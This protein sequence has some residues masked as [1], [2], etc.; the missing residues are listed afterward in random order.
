MEAE[1]RAVALEAEIRGHK[2]E[3]RRRRAQMAQAAAALAELRKALARRG[4]GLRLVDTKGE[5]GE[6]PWPTQDETST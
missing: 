3:I 6:H 5:G 4:I 2:A 1:A